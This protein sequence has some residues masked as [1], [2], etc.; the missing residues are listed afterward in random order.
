MSASARLSPGL[1]NGTEKFNY[2]HELK[3]CLK[4]IWA[5]LILNSHS[6]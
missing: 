4:M 2:L 6:V 1:E 3:P 5:L